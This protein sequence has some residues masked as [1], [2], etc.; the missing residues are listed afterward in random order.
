MIRRLLPAS[1]VVGRIPA[2]EVFRKRFGNPYAVIHRAD[3]HT[4]LP[5]GA[6]GRS[7]GRAP[8]AP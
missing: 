8:L 5:D 7:V 6:A 4:C 1:L 3:I 2:Y